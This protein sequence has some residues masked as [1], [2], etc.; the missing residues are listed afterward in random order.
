MPCHLCYAL[1]VLLI[2]GPIVSAASDPDANV[3]ENANIIL[4]VDL[5]ADTTPTA[6]WQFDGGDLP[7]MTTASLK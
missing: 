5:S 1:Y 2:A 7:N 4:T 6:T 3:P